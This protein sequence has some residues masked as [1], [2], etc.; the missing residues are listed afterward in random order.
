[1]PVT[2]SVSARRGGT[3]ALRIQFKGSNGQKVLLTSQDNIQSL[4][5]WLKAVLTVLLLPHPKL[6]NVLKNIEISS[7]IEM[8][9]DNPES[10]DVSM[11][12][13]LLPALT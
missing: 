1:M 4:V 2:R 10:I 3:I 6:T 9:W 8:F 12:S 11:S 5:P 7:I 13:I